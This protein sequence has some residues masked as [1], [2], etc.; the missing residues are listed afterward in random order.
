[1][2][3]NLTKINRNKMKILV[4]YLML[5]STIHKIFKMSEIMGEEMTSKIIEVIN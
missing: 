4:I 2:I 3:S 1:M 5:Q